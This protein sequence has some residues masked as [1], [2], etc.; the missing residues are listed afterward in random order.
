MGADVHPDLTELNAWLI[1]AAE[2]GAVAILCGKNGDMDTIGSAI[3]LS[4]AFPEAMACGI[5]M[6]KV[7]R[8]V[9]ESLSAPFRKMDSN[10]PSWPRKLGGIVCVDAAAPSQ[11][12]IP[13]PEGVPVCIIDHHATNDWS[14]GEDC[15]QVL[16]PVRAT[17]QIILSYF[18]AFHPDG[19][20]EPVRR[21]LLAG[22]VTDTGRFKHADGK[23]LQ[24]A[25]DLLL[26]GDIDYQ[27]FIEELESDEMTSS[28]R[29]AL[30]AGLGRVQATSA[31]DWHL[32]HTNV[33]SNESQMCA[34]LLRAGAEVALVSRTRDGQTRLTARA[35]RTA[36]SAGVHLGRIF[37]GMMANVGGDGGG[38]D[39][40]AGWSGCTDSTAVISS[41]IHA[42][43]GIKRAQ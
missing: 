40:A 36:T 2:N 21:L 33:G 10:N 23:A 38:H 41:F 4:T 22:L 31:G 3:S 16:W 30:A 17:T 27:A 11:I 25:A 34:V 15:L 43:T 39:G 7:A 42:L 18:Q 28:E 29:G 6:S 32:L 5:G 37:E 9:T 14:L 20:S 19:L 1:S 12:G 26:G 8:K 35:T 13:L 24:A